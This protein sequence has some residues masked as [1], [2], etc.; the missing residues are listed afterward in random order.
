[1]IQFKNILLTTDFSPHSE[2]AIPYAG[3]LAREFQG[4]IRLL[5]VFDDAPTA[6]G[7][8]PDV[9]VPY[10][11][12]T[13]AHKERRARLMLLAERIRLD[14]RVDVEPVMREGL[15]RQ[16]ILD[17]ARDS[18][19]DCIVIATHGHTGIPH[20]L[21]G[22]VAEQ[23]VRLSSCPVMTIRPPKLETVKASV[24]EESVQPVPA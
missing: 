3:E 19:A 15:A 11:W 7:I 6:A 23:I 24:A 22:S 5:H 12:I 20:F 13:S 17:E 10:D 2:A 4:R 21:F 9:F 18:H 1:M 16:G 8:S 14:E